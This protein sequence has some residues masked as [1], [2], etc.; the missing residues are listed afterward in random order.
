M[1]DAVGANPIARSTLKNPIA[2]W[3]YGWGKFLNVKAKLLVL[4]ASID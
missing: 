3:V 1:E 2:L 4:N